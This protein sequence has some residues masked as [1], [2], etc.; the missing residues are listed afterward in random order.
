M[1]TKA[2]IL[3]T[4]MD[5]M[6]KCAFFTT[7]R[8]KRTIQN[9]RK[10]AENF[11]IFSEKLLDNLINRCYIIQARVGKLRVHCDDAGDCGESR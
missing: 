5:R 9:V 4:T 2:C 10:T 1:M 3:Q 11:V 6:H 8:A 7:G